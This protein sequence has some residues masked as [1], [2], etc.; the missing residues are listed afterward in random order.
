MESKIRSKAGKKVMG[1]IEGL[2]LSIAEVERLA[3]LPK[4]SL[5]RILLGSKAISETQIE[6]LEEV[7]EEGIDRR[8]LTPASY[9]MRD[10]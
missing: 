3:Y 10:I 8:D 1:A 2:G 4:G 6:R 5:G 9:Y 7:I